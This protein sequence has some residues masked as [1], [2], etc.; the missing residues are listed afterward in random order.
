MVGQH[1]RRGT[2]QLFR[3]RKFIKRGW[4]INAGQILK[5]A[6]QVSE[7][8]LNNLE[9]LEDQLTGVDVAYFVQLITKLKEK[10]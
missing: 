10:D 4:S 1:R 9:V 5:I 8:D 3:L 6:F 7:L 2:S